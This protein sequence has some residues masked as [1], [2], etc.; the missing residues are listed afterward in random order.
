[1][2]TLIS[3]S[4]PAAFAGTVTFP[5]TICHEGEP[6]APG[7]QCDE[8][9]ADRQ[10]SDVNTLLALLGIPAG[11]ETLAEI[12]VV[13]PDPTVLSVDLTFTFERDTGTFL[14]S[15]GFC[16]ASAVALIDPVINKEAWAT[17]CLAA[18][19]EI[20]DDINDDVGETFLVNLAPGAVLIFYLIPNYLYRR[21]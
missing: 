1:V 20:F 15:F 21:S 19:T 14:F 10:F 13:T 8:T 6:P 5:E 3:I 4:V 7:V 16:P 9:P 11:S 17:A 2:I 18:A 12:F